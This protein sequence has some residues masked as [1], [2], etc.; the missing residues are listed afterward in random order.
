MGAS[1]LLLRA[2]QAADSIDD[3]LAGTGVRSG[4]IVHVG[5]DDGATTAAIALNGHCAVQGNAIGAQST[6]Q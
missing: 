2:G 6:L 3:V 5:C 1:L 4:L